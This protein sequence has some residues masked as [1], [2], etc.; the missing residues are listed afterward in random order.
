MK[1]KKTFQMSKR[2]HYKFIL[3]AILI[4]TG[5]AFA[6]AQSIHELTIQDALDLARKNNIQVKTALANLN[7][8]EQTNKQLTADALPNISATGTST[9][10]FQIPVIVLAANSFGP[11]VPVASQAVS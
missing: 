1:D 2:F 3:T 7:V 6:Q 5:I 9:N 4:L 8:Q 10:Y 11:G